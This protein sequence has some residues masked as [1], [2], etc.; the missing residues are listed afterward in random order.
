[1]SVTVWASSDVVNCLPIL[2]KGPSFL[3]GQI[4]I[5]RL[6]FFSKNM[7]VV[8]LAQMGNFCFAKSDAMWPMAQMATG[9]A[10][11]DCKVGSLVHENMM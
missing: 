6:F 8:K 2:V 7:L 1:M 5:A 11:L 9:T 10:T 4:Q 3:G